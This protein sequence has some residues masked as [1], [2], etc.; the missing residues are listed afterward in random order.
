MLVCLT[1]AYQAAITVLILLKSDLSQTSIVS[2]TA[3]AEFTVNLKSLQTQLLHTLEVCTFFEKLLINWAHNLLKEMNTHAILCYLVKSLNHVV[4]EHVL[5]ERVKE[6]VK[7]MLTAVNVS[8]V[9]TQSLMLVLLH[10]IEV[11]R[12]PLLNNQYKSFF[13]SF[14]H[15]CCKNKHIIIFNQYNVFNDI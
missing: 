2:N 6:E 15:F 12:T 11:A 14:Y 3:K 1:D 8:R 10:F 13:N 5:I 9:F 4:Y 7:R